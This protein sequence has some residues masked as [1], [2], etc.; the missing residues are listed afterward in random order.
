MHYK[1]KGLDFQIT[2]TEPFLK[3]KANIRQLGKSEATYSK[4]NLP[5]KT[6]IDVFSL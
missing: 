2:D 5:E 4:K 1:V 6:E 3:G